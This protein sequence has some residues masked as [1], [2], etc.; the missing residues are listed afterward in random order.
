VL[1]KGSLE[2]NQ[3]TIIKHYKLAI[4]AAFI[5]VLKST[6]KTSSKEGDYKGE[7]TLLTI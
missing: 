6:L 3:K 7:R 1:I 2:T 4:V 5:S